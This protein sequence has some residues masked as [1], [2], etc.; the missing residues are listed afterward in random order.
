MRWPG[1]ARTPKGTKGAEIQRCAWPSETVATLD[2]RS[3]CLRQCRAQPPSGAVGTN[4]R[5]WAHPLFEGEKDGVT[6]GNGNGNG[7]G[8]RLVTTATGWEAMDGGEVRAVAMAVTA[9]G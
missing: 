3:L 6:H 8:V 7:N 1:G 5:R 2:S 9:T 4:A